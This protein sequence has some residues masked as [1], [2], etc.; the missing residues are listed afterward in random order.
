MPNDNSVKLWA[1]YGSGLCRVCVLVLR[2][3]LRK[4]P[5]APVLSLD[6]HARLVPGS[7]QRF[8]Q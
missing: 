8:R 3:R 6:L 2:L 4:A 7:D 1:W 5:L